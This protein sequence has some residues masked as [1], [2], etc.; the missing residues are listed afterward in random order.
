MGIKIGKIGHH[1][2]ILDDAKKK[3]KL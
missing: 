3:S 2:S 1:I